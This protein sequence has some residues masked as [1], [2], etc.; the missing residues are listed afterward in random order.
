M[1]ETFASDRMLRRHEVEHQTGFS[2]AH[3][4]RLMAQDEFPRPYRL[5]ARAVGWK[6]SE[7]S[8]WLV[9]RNTA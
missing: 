5:S 1:T 4:Y 8:N 2:R 7:I 3:I 9:S 6:Q